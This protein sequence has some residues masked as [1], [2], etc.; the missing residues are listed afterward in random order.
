MK[1]IMIPVKK[2]A[3]LLRESNK[4]SRLEWGGVDN[5]DWYG[6]SLCEKDDDGLE[7]EDIVEMDDEELV[8]SYGYKIVEFSEIVNNT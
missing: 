1:T 4:L 6:E 2:L 5:W 3:K 8:K 7:Y